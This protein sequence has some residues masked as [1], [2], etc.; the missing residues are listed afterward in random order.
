[1]FY[2][3]I[4]I[5][6]ALLNEF[7][8][9]GVRNDEVLLMMATA[10]KDLAVELNVCVFTSTQVNA[11]ADNNT[12]IRNESSL[13]GGRSTINKADNGMIMARPTK[14]ELETLEPITAQHGKPNLVTDI[15]KVRSG[16]WTQVRIWSVMDLGTMKRDDLFITDSR[17][18]VI[19]DFYTGDEYDIC[20]WEEDEFA[21]IKRKVDWIN[22][23]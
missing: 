15:F 6:P 1:V 20:N 5:G 9:F 17:L 21:E 7:R 14:E 11:N 2:D 19:Q 10:L 16:E 12:N 22:G 23:L 13:A 18:E 4:F 3:Y 8:G